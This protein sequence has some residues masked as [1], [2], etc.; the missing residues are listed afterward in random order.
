MLLVS[1]VSTAHIWGLIAADYYPA[2]VSYGYG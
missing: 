2:N 1:T